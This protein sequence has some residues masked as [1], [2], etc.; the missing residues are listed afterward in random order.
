MKLETSVLSD[1]IL[2]PLEEAEYLAEDHPE[3]AAPLV[4]DLVA[5][6]RGILV[7]HDHPN[8][9]NC[10]TCRQLWPCPTLT[11]T[12]RLVQDPQRRLAEVLRAAAEAGDR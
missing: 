10:R 7:E 1:D 11:T 8:T 2:A 5:V 12:A 3:R 9:L 4:A 6:I